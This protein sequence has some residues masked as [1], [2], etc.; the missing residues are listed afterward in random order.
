MQRIG[1]ADVRRQDAIG[2][3][4]RLQGW[5]RTRRDS[6]AG[7]SF[8]EAQRR[9]LPGQ[10]PGHR[11]RRAWRTTKSE[12]KHLTAGCSVTVEGEVKAVAAARA[13]RPELQAHSVD[14]ARLGRSRDL[15]AA[16]ET[17]LVR[18][19]R[20]SG[21]ICGRGP[22]PSAPSPACATASAARSTTSSRRTAFSTSTRRSSRPATAKG[23]ARC[24]G[25]HARPGQRS[26]QHGRQGR[27]HAGL[28]RPAVAT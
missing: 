16:E 7:F 1:V 20:A 23:P 2:K 28:L 17:A 13:R 27:L 21:P 26:P 12:I 6:K 5:I 22:T 25:H 4:V 10:H 9:L 14:R 24:S 11:R 18:E 19:P 3:Q 8:L 15:S